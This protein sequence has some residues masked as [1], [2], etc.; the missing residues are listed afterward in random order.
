MTVPL[1]G[2]ISR[3]NFVFTSGQICLTSEEKL[4]KES[5]EEQTRQVM[6][7]LENVLKK[8]G[9]SFKDVVKTTIY[10]TDMAIY[11]DVNKIY[12]SFLKQPYP[13]REMICV[14]ELP[15]GAKVEI[16]MIAAKKK[17]I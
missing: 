15:L 11:N 10:V 5:I 7:N 16:S 4:L 13:A 12:A 2:A 17:L 1:S 14:K 8:E 6:E 3:N 9:V